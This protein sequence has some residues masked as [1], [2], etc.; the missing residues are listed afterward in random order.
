VSH[1]DTYWYITNRWYLFQ[2]HYAE[3]LDTGS[4]T[5]SRPLVDYPALPPIPGE[6]DL[7]GYDHLGDLSYYGDGTNGYLVIPVEYRGKDQ[8]AALALVSTPDLTYV[9]KALLPGQVYAAAC[10]V[11]RQ[12]NVYVPDGGEISEIRRFR[13]RWD[14]LS[15][16]VVLLEPLSS[17]Q[18]VGTAKDVQGMA[19]SESG[20][21]LFTSSGNDDDFDPKYGLMVY[22]TRSGAMVTRSDVAWMPFLY[23]YH[24]GWTRWEEPEGMTIWD[25]DGAGAPGIS[26]QLH[27]L[28][29]DNEEPTDE[30][31]MKHYTDV[32]YANAAGSG[33]YGRPDDPFGSVAE[34]HAYAWDGA[35][36]DVFAG[37]Y[38]EALR[39]EKRVQLRVSGGDATIGTGGQM[40]LHGGGM[41]NLGERAGLTLHP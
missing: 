40:A 16:G 39:V 14:L 38:P 13:L 8:E 22:D 7:A 28:L 21:L 4:P 24:P 1:D 30:I 32:I 19:F 37:S 41:V 10:A 11:D 20:R 25:L 9:G 6:P 3:N 34:A 18:L 27:V 36:I 15:A 29:L 35:K 26:G 2:Y 12:G 5:Q 31:Y 33:E 23:E 17:F